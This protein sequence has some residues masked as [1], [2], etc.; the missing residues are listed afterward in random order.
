M[1]G[2]TL[3]DTPN[4]KVKIR[5]FNGGEIYAFD[6]DRIIVTLACRPI[7]YTEEDLF[8]VRLSDGRKIVTTDQ[9]RQAIAT[10]FER[11]GSEI[12]AANLKAFDM[13]VESATKN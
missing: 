12:V 7:S 4:G 9:L 1:D 5:D 3:I 13:G 11:K 8:E 2:D 10:V 6:G